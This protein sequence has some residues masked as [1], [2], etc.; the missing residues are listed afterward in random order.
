MAGARESKGAR[1]KLL[2]IITHVKFAEI[3]VLELRKHVLQVE[4]DPQ[5]GADDNGDGGN[6]GG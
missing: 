1:L 2:R 6:E 4:C 5:A 3:D